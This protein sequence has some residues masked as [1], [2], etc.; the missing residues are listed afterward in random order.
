MAVQ[1]LIMPEHGNQAYPL[2]GPQALSGA[3]AGRPARYVAITQEQAKQAMT[4]MG[5]PE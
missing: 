2:T 5:M 3:A 1:A 4:G